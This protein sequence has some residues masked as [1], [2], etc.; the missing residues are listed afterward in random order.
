M[1]NSCSARG[2]IF[3]SCDP[4]NSLR[5][6][7]QLNSRESTTATYTLALTTSIQFMSSVGVERSHSSSDQ[8]AG[9][10][11]DKKKILLTAPYDVWPTRCL[12]FVTE[13]P[14]ESWRVFRLK[15]PWHHY[16]LDCTI[17][18]LLVVARISTR[19]VQFTFMEATTWTCSEVLH[20][21][22]GQLDLLCYN[23]VRHS[24]DA[25]MLQGQ[26]MALCT[27]TGDLLLLP[28]QRWHYLCSDCSCDLTNASV[29]LWVDYPADEVQ[30]SVDP[31]SI[32]M[33]SSDLQ[34]QK[35]LL[36]LVISKRAPAMSGTTSFIWYNK[37]HFQEGSG[38]IA[39]ATVSAQGFVS[40]RTYFGFDCDGYSS[41]AF[42]TKVS[43]N[44]SNYFNQVSVGHDYY[45]PSSNCF[46]KLVQVQPNYGC[47][48][49]N[50][51][52]DPGTIKDLQVP[53]DPGELFVKGGMSGALYLL[54]VMWDGPLGL[55]V[56]PGHVTIRGS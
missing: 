28:N 47:H 26:E 17:R 24:F 43:N 44:H 45:Y 35:I 36:V 22:N 29:I 33:T 46:S 18:K 42:F 30:K 12:K 38:V 1:S 8:G 10:G 11:T 41:V 31:R 32:N 34:P 40:H 49:D 48:C 6:G 4:F 5:N 23:K 9:K 53:W 54:H 21:K 2:I 52:G 55:R 15:P 25:K 13:G 16:D 14:S 37:D 51:H 39:V 7:D 56:G 3:T 20:C 50:H 27:T 19:S